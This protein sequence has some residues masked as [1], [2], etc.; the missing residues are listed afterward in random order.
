MSDFVQVFLSI[1]LEATPF[2]LIG[3]LLSGAMEV[4]V[5]P[6]ALGRL[7]PRRTLPAVAIGAACGV[8]LPMCECGIIPVVRRLLRKGVPLGAA[9]A[10]MLA[11]PIVNPIVL[12]STYVAFRFGGDGG[13]SPIGAFMVIARGGVAFVVAVLTGV[14]VA[15]LAG[16]R[17]LTVAAEAEAHDHDHDEHADG[18]ATTLTGKLLAV[19]RHGAGDFLE[20]L[21][22]LC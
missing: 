4:F 7:M 13:V 16:S 21:F 10:Y 20:I 1:I 6:G 17:P 14:V 18:R 5:P 19:L 2:I 11:A 9:V 22:F 15:R 3:S 12:V 8:F